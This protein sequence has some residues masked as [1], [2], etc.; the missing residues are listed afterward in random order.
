MGEGAR[1]F[2][3][4]RLIEAMPD[5]ALIV[6]AAGAVVAANDSAAALAGSAREDLV[7]RPVAELLTAEEAP[8]LRRSGGDLLDVE[9]SATPLSDG[10]RLLLVRDV[11][12]QRRT[13]S[14]LADAE[15]IAGIGVW[16]W[17]VP[18]DTVIWSR[19]A[20]R[21]FDKPTSC[22]PTFQLWLDSIHPDDRDPTAARVKAAFEEG[23]DYD[24]EHRVLRDDGSVRHLH[25]RGQVIV[26]DEGE[27][28]RLVGVSQDVTER[29]LHRQA[30]A[31]ATARQQAVLGA[32]GEGICGLDA[33]GRVSFANPAAAALLGGTAEELVGQHLG[34]RLRDPGTGD[35]DPIATAILHGERIA[36]GRALAR[37][38]NGEEFPISYHCAP[39]VSAGAPAGAVITFADARERALY[40]E[41]L[42]FLAEH[43]ALTGLLNR[44]RFEEEVAAQSLYA[45]RYG[46]AFSVLVLDLDHFKDVN[47]TRGHGPGDEL[48]RTT[49]RRLESA[50][51]DEGALARLGGDEFAILLPAAGRASAFEVAERLRAAIS[52]HLMLAGGER[53]Q[54]TASVGVAVCSEVAPDA[55]ALISNADVAMY[56][57]KESGRNRIVEY[58]PQL[59]ARTRMEERLNW[60]TQLR[61]ALEEDGFELFAQ[62]ILALDPG[63]PERRFEVLL[64]L[65]QPDGSLATPRS[66]LPV[67]ERHGLIREVDRWVV[68]Q[69]VRIAA[70]H[71]A[72]DT[73]LRLEINLSGHSMVDPELPAFIGELLRSE[74]ASPSQLIFE[75]TET[76]AIDSLGEAR[77]LAQSL[78][79]LGCEFAIDDFGA[80]FGS[81]AY[82]K[83]LPSQYVKIDGDFI[84][85]LPVSTDDQLVVEAIAAIARGM[86]KRTIAEFV[87]SEEILRKLA[88]FEIDFAQGFHVGRPEPIAEAIAATTAAAGA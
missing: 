29:V 48:I 67:A 21:L 81:F 30:L 1:A 87:E 75:V 53:L 84:R 7:G 25:C 40:E 35:E 8:C 24:F 11:R 66:F 80:G 10:G 64:R 17:H 37:R 12:Q 13:A 72:D 31:E 62:P 78:V 79:E 54:I 34:S 42:R 65:P 52:D 83:H 4:G 47:D 61:G 56:E 86:G 46:G 38:D 3:A 5:A 9:A 74:G 49:A 39:I 23:R 85:R 69:A 51:G 32:A 82:L 20:Y 55:E 15:R 36:D 6:D 71:A 57:A 73:P 22:Q 14:Q 44:N 63:T 77:E 60:S 43:D 28:V 68:S 2:E 41:R 26:N 88:E 33:S 50:L 70:R 45:Q 76:T 27:V 16:E 19:E 58:R 59:G 18:S